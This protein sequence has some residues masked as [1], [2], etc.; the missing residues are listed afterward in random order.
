[1]SAS[2]DDLDPTLIPFAKD[3]VTAAGAAGLLPQVTSTRRSQAQQARLY[4]AY[5]AGNTNYPVAPPGTSAHEYGF[6]FDMITSPMSALT[7]VGATWEDWGG[8]WGGHYGDEIHFEAPGFHVT[9]SQPSAG[10]QPP[11]QSTLAKIADFAV[12]F[13]PGVDAMAAAGYVLNLFP[14]FGQA[15]WAYYLS[16]PFEL[17]RLMLSRV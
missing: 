14:D 7:D 4:R 1:M 10:F 17:Y 11:N 6:A 12:S 9:G 8:V 13:L 3:L 15:E 2:L 5:L 16:H